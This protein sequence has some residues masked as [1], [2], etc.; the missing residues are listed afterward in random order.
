MIEIEPDENIW[1]DQ[2]RQH[3]IKTDHHWKVWNCLW[4]NVKTDKMLKVMNIEKADK[5]QN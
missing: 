2:Y 4:Q 3:K 1:S 5:D